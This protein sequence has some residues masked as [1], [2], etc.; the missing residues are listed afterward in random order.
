MLTS[1]IIYLLFIHIF[2]SRYSH[3]FLLLLNYLVCHFLCLIWQSRNKCLWHLSKASGVCKHT[4]QIFVS[5]RSNDLRANMKVLV[6]YWAT[7]R[8][9]LNCLSDTFQLF[10]KKLH[11]IDLNLCTGPTL[12]PFRT[13]QSIICSSAFPCWH[14]WLHK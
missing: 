7:F 8:I 3:N 9:L 12:P 4:K 2:L 13:T 5:E 14:T 11:G 6:F 10:K 1:I